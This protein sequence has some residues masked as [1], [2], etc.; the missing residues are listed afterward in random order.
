MLLLE[1]VTVWEHVVLAALETVVDGS[2][3]TEAVS[4]E[5]IAAALA[6]DEEGALTFEVHMHSVAFGA[7]GG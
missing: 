4:K 5:L 2:G 1:L 6:A 3:M 7:A